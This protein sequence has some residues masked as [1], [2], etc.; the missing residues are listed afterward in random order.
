MKRR[1]LVSLDGLLDTRV[2]VLK[3]L[4]EDNLEKILSKDSMYFN[5][6]IDDFEW[7]GAGT[8]E[9]FKAAYAA[10]KDA[11]IL[12]NSFRTL[13][14]SHLTL[15][16]TDIM[17]AAAEHPQW[18]G[19]SVDVNVWPYEL[20]AQQKEWFKATI[21]QAIVGDAH[22]DDAVLFDL[23]VNM[24]NYSLE[25]LTISK[26]G[27]SWDIVYLYEFAE[28]TDFRAKDMAEHEMKAINSQMIAPTLFSVLPNKKT[29][30][31][32][33]GGYINPFN[34]TR[35]NFSLWIQLSF[36]NP[37]LFSIPDPQKETM[38]L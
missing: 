38:G 12:A 17:L 3:M 7:L 23:E 32:P 14:V 2:G 26:I 28:W 25:E 19:M 35:R 37:R 11:E 21:Q 9:K 33:K 16:V 20:T 15:Q 24:V 22:E 31:L 5:R 10:R 13:L 8:T 18:H 34:E 27:S 29:L 30:R 6:V 4:N 36:Q 1:F